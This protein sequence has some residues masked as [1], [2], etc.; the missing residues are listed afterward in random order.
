MNVRVN[1]PYARSDKEPS[2]RKMEGATIVTWTL[3]DEEELDLNV[4]AKEVMRRPSDKDYQIVAVTL[5]NGRKYSYK[6]L[7]A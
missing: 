7:Y 5:K 6:E 3:E 2:R 1:N 4:I